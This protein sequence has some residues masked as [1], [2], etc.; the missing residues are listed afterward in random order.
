M[1][2]NKYDAFLDRERENIQQATIEANENID[3][4]Q[5]KEVNNK[6][7]I[8]KKN[9]FLRIIIIILCLLAASLLTY[10]GVHYIKNKLSE[11]ET[12][13]TT[14]TQNRV[15]LYVDNINKIRKFKNENKMIYLLPMSFKSLVIDINLS[16]NELI[17]YRS[18]TYNIKSDS[19]DIDLNNDK[20]NYLI[21]NNGIKYEEELKTDE[22]EF[23][24]YINESKEIILID[25]CINKSFI[26]KENGTFLI[27]DYEETLDKIIIDGIEYIKDKDSIINNGKVYT[28][29]S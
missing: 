5:A 29:S 10:Y 18:G 6:I 16:N 3:E 2:N 8:K 23:K 14:T 26:I 27:K 15:K 4:N 12:T 13:T 7:K 20:I 28:Y 9:I 25:A 19:I 24:Y 22:S 1:N 11:E 21:T 17:D